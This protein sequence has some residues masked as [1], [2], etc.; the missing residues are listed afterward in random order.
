MQIAYQEPTTV[1]CLSLLDQV[2]QITKYIDT[3]DRADV[4]VQCDIWTERT[5]TRA[6]NLQ[7][8]M[9]G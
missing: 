4:A 9:A 7:H 6:R 2:V 1:N 8:H 5:L 3:G